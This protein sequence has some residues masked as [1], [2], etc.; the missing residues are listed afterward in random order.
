MIIERKGNLCVMKN[1]CKF[2]TCVLNVDGALKIFQENGLRIH[3]YDHHLVFN[4][5]NVSK[6]ALEN[7]IHRF[8]NYMSRLRNIVYYIPIPPKDKFKNL[9]FKNKKTNYW[10][11]LKIILKFISKLNFFIKVKKSKRIDKTKCFKCKRKLGFNSFECK[12]LHYF[13]KKHRL[14]F[15]HNCTFNH[16]KHNQLKLK[17][18]NV[19]VNAKKIEK[20]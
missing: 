5:K 14:S 1:K 11:K 6:I 3:I 8:E 15:D 4:S 18:A 7:C 17:K 16:K 9:F 2:K 19:I 20:I 13:C 10:R 12:C